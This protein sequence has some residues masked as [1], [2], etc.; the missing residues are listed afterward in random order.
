MKFS[1]TFI[2]FCGILALGGCAYII[3]P[4]ENAPRNNIVVG[5]PHRP[6]LNNNGG[7]PAPQ[8]SNAPH[9]PTQRVAHND[10]PALPPVDAAT[11]AEAQQEM[12]Q[13]A[14]VTPV[15]ANVSPS[16]GARHVPSENAPFQVAG[17]YPSLMNVP[18]RPVMTGPDSTK[19]RLGAIQTDLQQERSDAQIS[20]DTLAR[21]AAAEPSML[22]PMPGAP[23]P[24]ITAAPLPAPVAPKPIHLVPPGA[25]AAAPAETQPQAMLTFKPL[26]GNANPTPGT[27][28]FPPPTPLNTASMP[29]YN[30]ASAAP[31]MM[32][33]AENPADAASAPAPMVFASNTAR[34]NVIKG[35]FDPLAAADS[36]PLG[37]PVSTMTSASAPNVY[38]SDGY[39]AAS[40]YAAVRRN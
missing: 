35:D 37:A 15:T 26:P 14:P 10:M 12:A 13:A 25:S 38:A 3:P 23:A 9:A 31:V 22:A 36:A 32:R 5:E 34:P 24:S 1:S 19:E 4:E 40:R 39:M 18:E 27:L 21:D 8:S 33:P 17:D 2:S 29:A 7:A 28:N 16:L 30:T 11:Q 20:K 6:Q